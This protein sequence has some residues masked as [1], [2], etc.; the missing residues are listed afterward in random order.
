MAGMGEHIFSGVAGSMATMSATMETSFQA[1]YSVYALAGAKAHYGHP[2]V[3]NKLFI[4]TRGGLSKATKEVH[5][6][7]DV[8]GAFNHTLRGGKMC[9]A[10]YMT[11]QKG[12]DLALESINLFETKITRGQVQVRDVC[13]RK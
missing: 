11:V 3:M 12:R 13:F 2:D 5:V 10:T 1:M 9:H 7:E 4:V 8:F 6:S